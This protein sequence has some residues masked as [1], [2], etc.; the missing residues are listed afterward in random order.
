MKLYQAAHIIENIFK[1][2]LEYIEFEDGSGVKSNYRLKGERQNNF[3]NLK[4]I[5]YGGVEQSVKNI[6]NKM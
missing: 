1:K 6:T 5:Q 4:N 3:I 2:E